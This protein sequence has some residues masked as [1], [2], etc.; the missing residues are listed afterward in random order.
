MVVLVYYV[1]CNL[2]SS[3]IFFACIEKDQEPGKEARYSITY[4]L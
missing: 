4:L 2:P 1:E 3:P